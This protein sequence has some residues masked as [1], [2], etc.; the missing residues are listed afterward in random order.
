MADSAGVRA[1]PREARRARAS[2]LSRAVAVAVVAG[3]VVIVAGTFLPWLR[4]GFAT[5]NSF[6]AAGLI[7]RL[8]HPP[9]I[10]GLLLSMWPGV[11][12][13]C[14]VAVAALMLGLRRTGLAVATV[15]A[16]AVGA[17][18]VSVLLLP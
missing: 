6:R 17:V 5:R 14:A 7:D 3:V 12:L 8:L 2:Q 4:T 1:A 10:A 15:V 11:V 16:L 13:L 18:S 9:G